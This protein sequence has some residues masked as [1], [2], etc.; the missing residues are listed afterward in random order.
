MSQDLKTAVILNPRAAA[1]RAGR[2]WPE[3]QRALHDALGGYALFRTERSA[4]ATE[5]VRTA[6]QDGYERVVSVGGDGTHHEVVNGFFHNGRPVNPDALLGILPIGTG[7]DLGRTLRL[8]RGIGAVPVLTQGKVVE[9]DV[10][11]VNFRGRDDRIETA[12]FINVADFGAGGAVAEHVNRSSKRMGGFLSFLWGTTRTLARYR[13]PA[14]ELEI[15]GEKLEQRCLTVIVANAEYF[16]GGIHVARE[17]RLDDGLLD[18]F[19][20]HDLPYL[21]CLR[22]L[23]DFYTGQ[24]LDKPHLVRP[25]KAVRIA[26]RSPDRVLVNLDG[27]LPGQLPATVEVVPRAI[28]LI[29]NL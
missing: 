12:H 7:S 13:A 11:R 5:L 6:L 29:T 22:H 26:L 15:D 2:Q 24:V 18:V 20:V 1:G 23:R 19:V 25:F 16:G 21:T 17:A 8:P 4:H 28:R 10:G 27:E 14:F 9:S 3:I